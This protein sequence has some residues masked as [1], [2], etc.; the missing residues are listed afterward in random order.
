MKLATALAQA[1]R[2]Q[3]AE[4]LWTQAEEVIRSI[5]RNNEQAETLMELAAAL[6]QAQRWQQAESL[7]TQAEEVSISITDV[8]WQNISPRLSQ[9]P[10]QLHMFHQPETLRDLVKLLLKCSNHERALHTVQHSW[11]QAETRTFALQNF[12]LAL[13]LIFL[14][15]EIGG[16]L[17]QGFKW[18]DTFLES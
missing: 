5:P 16:A 1:E 12:D 6:T 8:H 7:W 13:E 10:K 3:Q 15:P 2:W 9:D 4:N 17:Y 11:L 14:K 18:V